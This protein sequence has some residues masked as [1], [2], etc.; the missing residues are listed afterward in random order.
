MPYRPKTCTT[1]IVF[2]LLLIVIPTGQDFHLC[3]RVIDGDIIVAI[4]NG[5]EEIMRL[6]GVNT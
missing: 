3:T 4:I 6:I 5:K 1:G 2:L